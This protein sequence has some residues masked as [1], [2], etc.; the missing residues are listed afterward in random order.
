MTFKT[1]PL[2]PIPS[3]TEPQ[4]YQYLKRLEDV[5]RGL[6]VGVKDAQTAA[7]SG[8]STAVSSKMDNVYGTAGAV[9]ILDGTGGLEDSGSLLTATPTPGA[10][11]VADDD[12]K[13]NGWVDVP[14]V[15]GFFEFDSNG[16]LMPVTSPTTSDV[17]ELDGNGDIQPK[18]A[19]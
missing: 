15:E 7:S 2:T 6:T 3:G 13:L 19:I 5:V 1:A 9:A 17:W 11:P 14:S 18:A 16:A 12:G 4:L 8:I 10:T